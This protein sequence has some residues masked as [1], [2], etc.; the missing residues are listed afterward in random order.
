MQSSASGPTHRAGQLYMQGG[1]VAA[2]R[3]EDGVWGVGATACGGCR[4]GVWRVVH[5][6]AHTTRTTWVWCNSAVLVR[7]IDMPRDVFLAGEC[8][9]RAARSSLHGGWGPAWRTI[10]QISQ[11][12][13]ASHGATAAARH[14]TARGRRI[15]R[16]ARARGGAGRGHGAPWHHSSGGGALRARARADGPWVQA[17]LPAS[18]LSPSARRRRVSGRAR[19]A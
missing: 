3:S 11:A 5:T 7:R 2:G 4:G 16:I 6:R 9:P 15:H 13:P 8:A 17:R 1:R 19:T 18:H 12:H 14:A 10:S